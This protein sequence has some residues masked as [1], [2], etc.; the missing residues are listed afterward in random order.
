[1]ADKIIQMPTRPKVPSPDIRRDVSVHKN[2]ELYKNAC[3]DFNLPIPTYKTPDPFSLEAL[4]S[5]IHPPTDI[6]A[7]EVCHICTLD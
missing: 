4:K 2:T 6:A 7:D 5:Q 3:E 1:M